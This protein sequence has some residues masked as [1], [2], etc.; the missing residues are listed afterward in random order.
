MGF[1]WEYILGDDCD[2]QEAYDAHL[3]AVNRVPD[4]EEDFHMRQM[5]GYL[6]GMMRDPDFMEVITKDAVIPV[7][8]TDAQ[9]ME[10]LLQSEDDEQLP[11]EET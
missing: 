3:D 4:A 9:L 5:T 10:T 8:K 1:D 7:G 11:F 2:M 6:C